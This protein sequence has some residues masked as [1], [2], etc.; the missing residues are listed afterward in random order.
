MNVLF[1]F[2]IIR[3]Y[4]SGEIVT[5]TLVRNPAEFKTSKNVPRDDISIQNLKLLVCGSRKTLLSILVFSFIRNK[6][7]EIITLDEMIS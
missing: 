3:N 7:M 1:L 6:N 2:Y 4:F 5:G